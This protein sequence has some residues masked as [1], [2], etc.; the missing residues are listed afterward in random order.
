MTTVKDNFITFTFADV[1]AQV[2][3]LTADVDS[4]AADLG[5]SDLLEAAAGKLDEV[6]DLID[7]ARAGLAPYLDNR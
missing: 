3:D 7:K 6:A 5:G 2:I 4:L 1:A